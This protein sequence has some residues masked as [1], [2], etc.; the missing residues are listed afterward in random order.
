MAVD[1]TRTLIVV[2]HAKAEDSAATDHD[3]EL[4]DRGRADAVAVGELLGDVLDPDDETVALVSTA[5]RARQTWKAA[6][7]EL[8]VPVEY[9]EMQELYE[10]GGD[11]V[12]DLLALLPD[13]IDAAVVVGHNPT[14][15]AVVNQLH[16]GDNDDLAAILSD[17]GLP[18][19]GVAVLEHDGD[20]ADLESGSCRL[21]R[22]ES[23]RG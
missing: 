15:E 10:A 1:S 22:L 23:P 20:W 21:V 16:D 12:V 4:T 17:R 11:E 14:M 19:A 13:E 3:R 9:R 8:A 7:G 18:T 6:Y 2:R 5:T